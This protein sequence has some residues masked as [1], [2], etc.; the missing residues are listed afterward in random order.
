MLGARESSYVKVLLRKFYSGIGNIAPR[1][2]ERREFGFGDF[3]RKI[4]FRHNAFRDEA[5]LKSYL[6]N[7]TPPFVSA[8][9]SE[10]EKPEG[11]PME[12]KGWIGGEL[13]FD[14]DASDLNLKCRKEHASSWVCENCLE[15]A[16]AETEKLIE[17]FLVPDFGFAERDISI[18]FSGNRGYHIHVRN[19]EVF[20]LDGNARKG[21]SNYITGN[22]IELNAFFPA[23]GRRGVRLEGPKPTDYGWG[24]KLANGVIRALNGGASDL[25]ELGID[26]KNAEMLVRKSAE[27]RLG[28]TT[29][30]WDK[31]NIPKKAEFW[32]NVLKNIAVKQSDLIDKNVSIDVYHLIRLPGTIHGDTGLIAKNVGSP[33]LLQKFDPMR[34][35]IAFGDAGVKVNVKG[36]P[37]FS[38]GGR[39]FGPYSSGTVSIPRYA[40]VYLI[41]KRYATLP[42]D[43]ITA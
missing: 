36:V 34:E 22:G 33:K 43:G 24:G 28:I 17:D 6:V 14:I 16:K 18:N 1:N 37:S 42:I 9:F 15:S 13:L 26:K 20:K 12:S 19:D 32:S 25:M 21:I 8:S 7:N 27:V 30:N 35:A 39:G 38:M 2:I 29:G 3:E 31:I 10:Y 23:L 5:S 11:R 41:L 40:A 4:V